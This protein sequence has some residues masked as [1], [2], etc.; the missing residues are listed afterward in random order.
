MLAHSLALPFIIDYACGDFDVSEE[1]EEGLLLA[2]KQ[3]DRVRRVRLQMAVPNQEYDLETIRNT[4]SA[5]YTTP[6][7]D[8]LRPSFK[9][10][11]TH[12]R[13]GPCHTRTYT[14]DRPIHPLPPKWFAP[15]VLV[16]TLAGDALDHL[17]IHCF[18]L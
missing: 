12:N 16:H 9:V 11:I 10:S 5:A 7:A 15:M 4:S 18:R 8:W 6:R 14:S 3:C 2:L 13:H 1:D 17:F